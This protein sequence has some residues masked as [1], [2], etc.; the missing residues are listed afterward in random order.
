MVPDQ[1]QYYVTPSR[2]GN[3]GDHI[4]FKANIDDFFEQNRTHNEEDVSLKRTQSYML[5]A[6]FYGAL[7]SYAR[8]YALGVIGRLNGWK[9]YDRD[10]YA[11]FD[12][13]EVPPGKLFR[14]F[15]WIIQQL[16]AHSEIFLE[17]LTKTGS[18]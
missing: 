17:I 14:F 6:L 7:M 4:D 15:F 8:V 11:E 12:I 1:Q 2:P 5:N 10:T 16:L 18:D 13:G 3:F 9:R